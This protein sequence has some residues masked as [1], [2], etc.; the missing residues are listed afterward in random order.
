[1]N[2][3]RSSEET[4]EF[5]DLFTAQASEPA[6]WI[7]VARTLRVG[8]R[9]VF[10]RWQEIEDVSQ[11]KDGVR[12]EK[13]GCVRAYML[14]T[15]VAFENVLKAIAVKRELLTSDG[16]RLRH[17]DS[18]RRRGG[19]GLS[20][21][22]SNLDIPLTQTDVDF[23]RRLEE[24]LVWGARYPVPIHAQESARAQ[25]NSLLTVRSYDVQLSDD[26]FDRLL[27]LALQAT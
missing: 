24:Y 26:L 18:L 9:P 3:S 10:A 15:A 8:A 11:N 7:E 5:E 19:H 2:R 20:E 23:L 6:A 4:E 14:L 22:A 1:L 25:K 16:D 12:L 21:I 27:R 17:H 13:L